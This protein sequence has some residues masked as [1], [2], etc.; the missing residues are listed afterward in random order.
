MVLCDG[1]SSETYLFTKNIHGDITRIVNA[2]GNLQ[3]SYTYDAHGNRTVTYN[4]NTSNTIGIIL[5]VG[6]I[7]ISSLT[8]FGYRGYCY[9][10]NTGLYYLQSRY[11]DPNTGRFINA[12][13]TDYLN[14][15][16]TVLGCNLFIYCENDPVNNVDPTG[17]LKIKTFLISML[18]DSALFVIAK[19][20]LFY[21][22]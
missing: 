7:I 1:E 2:N 13:S 21:L 10:A 8:P 5:R 4:S 16:G 14:V 6:Q 11:Y 9:D 17:T 19:K 15:S 18:I 12:D 3:V 20:L 22:G